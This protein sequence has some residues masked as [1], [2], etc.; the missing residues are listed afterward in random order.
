MISGHCKQDRLEALIQALGS[1]SRTGGEAD[2]QVAF[3][4]LE[5]DDGERLI[6]HLDWG[7]LSIRFDGDNGT[8]KRP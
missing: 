2:M 1:W 4:D 6:G 7:G 8:Q 5:P 3:L